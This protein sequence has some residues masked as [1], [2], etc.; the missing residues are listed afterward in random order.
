MRTRLLAL[1]GAIVMALSLMPGSAF[2]DDVDDISNYVTTYEIHADG[3]VS[4]KSTMS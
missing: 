3:S 4:V 2:A 1:F